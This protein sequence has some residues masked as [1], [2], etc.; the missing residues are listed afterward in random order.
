MLSREMAK[1][2]SPENLTP[3]GRLREARCCLEGPKPSLLPLTS[4]YSA[5]PGTWQEAGEGA[6]TARVYAGPQ[7]S[8]Y[9]V[10]GVLKSSPPRPHTQ[11]ANNPGVLLQVRL[12]Q[13]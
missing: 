3:T 6:I 7:G 13:V 5:I 1:R 11:E 12:G 2:C 9:T 10:C 4:V 8:R